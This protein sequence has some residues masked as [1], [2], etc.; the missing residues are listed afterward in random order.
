MDSTNSAPGVFLVLE[1]IDG[2]GKSTIGDRLAAAIFASGQPALLTREPGG[3][4]VGESIRG[5]LLA[6]AASQMTA[7]TEALLFAAA[8][9]QHVAEV[10]R[11]ALGKGTVVICDRYTDSTLAYQ[12]G[13]RGLS[14][15][16]LVAAQRLATD[17]LEPDL[18]LLLDLPVEVGLGRR[19]GTREDTN[20]LDREAREFH[21]RV[22]AA[23]HA[24]VD[25]DRDRWRVINADQPIDRVWSG[26]VDAVNETG[27]LRSLLL[28]QNCVAVAKEPL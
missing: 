10:I 13:G 7:E 20:R 4:E 25:L 22:R 26:I 16:L 19:F 6:P 23:Y 21:E 8:R 18:K 28:K 5:L 2:S 15:D 9:A 12:W 1:G 27:L 14:K 17:G 24:L 3:T 11:P